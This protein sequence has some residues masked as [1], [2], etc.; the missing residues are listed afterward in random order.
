M[1]HIQL[2][3]VTWSPD[4]QRLRLDGSVF[5]ILRILIPSSLLLS[6]FNQH[7]QIDRAGALF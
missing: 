5:Y 1:Y 7:L 3:V 2:D 6:Y 4:I